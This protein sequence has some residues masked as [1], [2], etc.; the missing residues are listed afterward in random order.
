M[1]III[2]V[3]YAQI[4]SCETYNAL[5]PAITKYIKLPNLKNKK[6]KDKENT[7]TDVF[8]TS[9]RLAE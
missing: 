1:I 6:I 7:L 5:E 2:I 3:L 8:D 9:D 4:C